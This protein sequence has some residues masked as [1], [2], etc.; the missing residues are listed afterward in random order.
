MEVKVGSFVGPT[1][2]RIQ[3]MPGRGLAGRQSIRTASTAGFKLAS[4]VV[5]DLVLDDAHECGV[6]C[7]TTRHRH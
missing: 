5:Q 4:R 3:L 1:S 2:L 7:L 6:A